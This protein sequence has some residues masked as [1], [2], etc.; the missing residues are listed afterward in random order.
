M[1]SDTPETPTASKAPARISYLAK[2]V[3]V[4]PLGEITYKGVAEI[5]STPIPA[6]ADPVVTAAYY[7]RTAETIREDCDRQPGVPTGRVVVLAMLR[8]G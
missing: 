2:Y 6:N 4:D 5:H 7:A 1:P 3:I 8:K